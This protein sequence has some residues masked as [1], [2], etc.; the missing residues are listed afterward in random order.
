MTA[1]TLRPERI[2]FF[3]DAALMQEQREACVKLLKDKQI[4]SEIVWQRVDCDNLPLLIE[5]LTRTVSQEPDCILEL[6]GGSDLVLA[7][8]GAVYQRM[9][10]N[11]KLQLQRFDMRTGSFFDCDGDKM[12]RNAPLPQLTVDEMIALRGG[13]VR[14]Q[15]RGGMGTEPWDISESLKREVALLWDISRQNPALWNSAVSILRGLEMQQCRLC[16]RVSKERLHRAASQAEADYILDVLRQL[17]GSG[18]LLDF[19]EDDSQLCYTYRDEA[20]HRLMAK[21]GNILEVKMLL[22]ARQMRE[23]DGSAWCTDAVNGVYIDWD[24]KFHTRYDAEKDTE[25]EIDVLLMR[26]IFPVFISCKNGMV[27]E[28]ELYKLGTVAD[29]FGGKFSRRVL[30]ATYLGKSEQSNAYLRQ[31]AADMHIT[32]IEHIHEMEDA[33]I[34]AALRAACRL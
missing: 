16:V 21:A 1:L 18:L 6:T 3:G 4:R 17:S 15:K 30:C 31:R 29:R 12:A 33:E 20:L 23:Q 22:L 26:S 9:K 19:A 11:R 14:Y 34:E 8:A 2:V 10:D 25:N 27:K 32:L 24:G 7:A 13:S 28:E 5:T